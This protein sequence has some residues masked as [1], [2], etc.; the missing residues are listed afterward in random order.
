MFLAHCKGNLEVRN[1]STW[2]ESDRS[3]SVYKKKPR[4]GFHQALSSL[5]C[6]VFSWFNNFK[7]TKKWKTIWN[8]TGKSPWIFFSQS[9]CVQFNS[10]QFSG[11]L[12][13][14][15]ILHC[16]ELHRT[17]TNGR[18]SS[19]LETMSRLSRLLC[20]TNGKAA[21]KRALWSWHS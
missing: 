4:A 17:C 19:K 21:R 20:W 15:L 13:T 6:Q 12:W 14:K 5:P 7:H 1:T 3:Y 2:H 11:S 8:T 10:H 18:V 9:K 16:N